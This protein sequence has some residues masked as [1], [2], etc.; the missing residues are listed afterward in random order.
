M[1]TINQFFFFI[2]LL[3]F[4]GCKSTNKQQEIVQL[5]NGETDVVTYQLMGDSIKTGY[6]SNGKIYYK[7]ISYQ[8]FNGI[9][10]REIFQYNIDGS[11]IKYACYL[12]DSLR[13]FRYYD[14][15][16][17]TTN[18]GGTGLIYLNNETIYVDTLKVGQKFFQNLRLAQPPHATLRVI[19]GDFV[20]DE[21]I[22]NF[23]KMPLMSLPIKEKLSGFLVEFNQP[24]EY[25]KVIYWSVEDSI[26]KS[27]QKGRLWRKFIVTP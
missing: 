10:E 26:S 3:W 24:G 13:Y 16:N 19:Y 20:D 23:D 4:I 22:R 6:Y 9:S 15:K 21:S 27:T 5:P 2:L 25:T 11:I 14:G 7:G 8:G 17:L 1:K 12:N 18:F